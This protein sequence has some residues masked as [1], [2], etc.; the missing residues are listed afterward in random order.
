MAHE[1]PIE[2]HELP[3]R[4]PEGFQPRDIDVLCGR[5]RGFWGHDGN[6]LWRDVLLANHERYHNADTRAERSRIVA[7]IVDDVRA[8][9]TLFVQHSEIDNCFFDIGNCKAR[10]KTGQALRD[11]NPDQAHAQ[12]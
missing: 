6:L 4:L 9:G 7:S 3:T 12:E 10:E 11:M 2:P 1:Q 8:N 5:G